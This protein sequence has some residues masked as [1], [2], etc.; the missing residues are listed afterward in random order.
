[1]K[2]KRI[3]FL[4][5]SLIFLVLFLVPFRLDLSKNI[6]KLKG[7]V[8]MSSNE[9]MFINGYE[10]N[11]KFKKMSGQNVEDSWPGENTTIKTIKKS[12]TLPSPYKTNDNI[13]STSD[14]GSPI[15][16]WYSSGTIYWYTTA[17]K[18]YLHPENQ[19]IF[20]DLS[21]LESI[22]EFNQFDSSKINNTYY[23]F[24]NC[25]KLKSIDLS[26]FDTSNVENM[27]SMFM[28]CDSLTSLDLSHFNTSKVT[29]MRQMVMDCDNIKTINVSH[30]DTSKVTDMSNMFSDNNSLISLD[31]SSFNTSKVTIMSDMF[32]RDYSLTSLDLSHF[33]T[34]NVKRMSA[35]F[36]ECS[37]LT[38]LNLSSFNTSKVTA[39]YL[40]FYGCSNLSKI[41]ASNSFTTSAI[42]TGDDYQM[43][44]LCNNLVGG[45]GT[46]YNANNIT[47]SYARIDSSSSPGYFTAPTSQIRIDK[48]SENQTVSTNVEIKGW[49]MSVY[50]TKK[51]EIYI[52]N[53]KIN[54]I[55]MQERQDVINA[56]SGYGTIVENPK[57]GYYANYDTSNLSSGNHTLKIKIINTNTNE[58]IKEM[59]RSFSVSKPKVTLHYNVN[60]GTLASQHGSEISISNS[61]VMSGSNPYTDV[62]Y[63]G[64]SLPSTGLP[65]YNNS[66]LINIVKTGYSTVPNEEWI[67]DS[68]RKYS[69]ETAYKASDFCDLSNGNCTVNLK[70]NWTKN[71]LQIK[72][73]V[74]GGTLATQH[75]STIGV[76]DSI[77][78]NNGNQ[79]FET[80]YYGDPLPDRG[81]SN[82]NNSNSINVVR[83]GYHV[84][85]GKEWIDSQGRVFAQDPEDAIYVLSDF[86]DITKESKTIILKIN[87]VKDENQPST[88]TLPEKDGIKYFNSGSK[89]STITNILG[90]TSNVK[91]F[92]KGVEKT[93]NDKI[94]TGDILKINND[95]Y[96][97]AILGDPNCDGEVDGA[98]ISRTYKIY[99][100]I[101]TSS[102][103][104]EKIAADANKD[105]T[106]DGGDISRIYKIYRGLYN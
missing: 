103:N 1:M 97:V 65:N 76:S 68:G 82:Y 34:S 28:D 89:L 46:R 49:V 52:D 54:N 86:A 101:L 59:T 78:T 61:T 90:T 106:I 27:G 25:K 26:N 4:L 29:S 96:E 57:P 77:I 100:K 53:T 79:I 94:F 37:S 56:I 72:Y 81:L 16:A 11:K 83:T 22:P 12:T 43:F 17:T 15:Y 24:Y 73:H 7:D 8:A 58:T 102:T 6:F 60:G 71:Y 50:A 98:D 42:T 45:N 9:T 85:K 44:H 13:V 70:V 32:A 104:A 91:I 38:S 87:W 62:I 3:I 67:T 40:M 2:N 99:R 39:M 63:Y 105:N 51:V 21:A 35:M 69:Q 20:S 5:V 64:Q 75:G 74:N 10:L 80:I 19:Y 84:E 48:P 41:Y 93:S 66:N 47:K 88:N 31:L 30:F 14:S 92:S 33:D 18:V 36:K 23:M 95:E 55:T